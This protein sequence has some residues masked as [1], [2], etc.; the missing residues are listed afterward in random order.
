MIPTK[1]P[2]REGPVSKRSPYFSKSKVHTA[3]THNLRGTGNAVGFQLSASVGFTADTQE[4]T[5]RV[6][7]L[8][9]SKAWLVPK[10]HSG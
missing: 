5:G 9:E 8:V 2:E 6:L 10:R 1:R 7:E 3:E 4:L